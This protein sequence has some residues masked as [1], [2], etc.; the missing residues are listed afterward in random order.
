M[1]LNISKTKNIM[2]IC[3]IVFIVGLASWYIVEQRKEN[4]IPEK[5]D[6]VYED[7]IKFFVEAGSHAN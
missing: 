2:L 7:Q 1:I 5:A 6:L 3:F 4:A